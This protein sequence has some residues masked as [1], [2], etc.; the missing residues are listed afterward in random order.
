M[1]QHNSYVTH[2]IHAYVVFYDT[3]TSK[4]DLITLNC[5]I[6]IVTGAG[7]K[8]QGM[9]NKTSHINAPIRSHVYYLLVG[10]V[11]S[12]SLSRSLSLSFLPLSCSRLPRF[13]N[14]VH[15]SAICT[16]WVITLHINF[17]LLLSSNSD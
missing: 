6:F 15:H 16:G 3:L 7:T 11:S 10:W 2:F 13:T 12:V 8:I 4:A 5:I 1:I 14:R 17:R 9:I